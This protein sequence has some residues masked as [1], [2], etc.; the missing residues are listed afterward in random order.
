[1]AQ[2]EKLAARGF[3]LY[4]G[5]HWFGSLN[6]LPNTMKYNSLISERPRFQRIFATT[7][8]FVAVGLAVIF[9]SN[10]CHAERPLGS[11]WNPPNSVDWAHWRGPLQNGHSLEVGLP[12]RFS[13]DGE[14]LLWRKEEFA[15]RATPIVMKDRVY[16]I[17][18]SEPETNKEGE[19]IVCVDAKTGALLWESPHNIFLSD[20]PSERI[21]WSSLIGDS[22]T[23]RVYAL[24]LG[25]LFQCLD[26]STGKV[27]WEHSMLEEYGMLSTYGGRTNFP[28]LF[29]D[30]VIISGVMTG[31][32]QTA[33]PAHR[34]VA[35]DK[36]TGAAIWLMSTRVRPE[37]TTY[38]TPVYTVLNGQAAMVLGAAD[39][40]VY[41]LQPR[42]GK[43]IWKYQASPRGINVTPLVEDGIVY[44]G[45]GEQ[46]ESDRSILGAVF[47]FDGNTSG[48]IPESKLLWSVP[49][50]TVSRSCPV[51]V[52]NRVYYI[53]DGGAMFGVNA[54][55][56][57]VEAEKKLGR[58]M[59]GSLV[60][61]DGKL[62]VGENTGR[63]WTLK[64]TE[65]GL[66][67]LGQT[68]LNDGSEIFGSFAI[69]NGRMFLPT[70]KALYCIGSSNAESKPSP[71]PTLPVEPPLTDMN[72]AHIQ[73]CPVEMLLVPG[74]TAKLQVRGYNAIGQ[75]VKLV[76]DA[77]FTV[78]G[79]GAV[80]DLRYTASADAKG[81]G[82]MITAALGEIKSTARAR[83][84]PPL[85]WSFDFE[86][87]KVPVYWIGSAYRHKPI[88]LPT[89]G[90]GLVKISTIPKGTRSQGFIGRPKTQEYTVQ[91]EFYALDTKNEVRTTKL[92]DMGLVNQR[93]TLALEGSQKLQIRSWVSLL[94]Q[95]FAKTI[96]FQWEPKTWYSL[97]F[98]SENKDGKAVL[99][100][101][102]WKTADPEP[103]V[104]T[105]EAEDETPNTNG[106][107]GIFGNS[108]DA[109]FYID[110]I[111]VSKE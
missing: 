47:A 8:T 87:K 15:T 48:D 95:R 103:D 92:P 64:P 2:P 17:C 111:K 109:E 3:L 30:M 91:G 51:K 78:E 107:P 32:D 85:P 56:G 93:Y 86:D 16:T 63:V 42:T 102:V 104:W 106:S 41:A 26:A 12:D 43:V 49:K 68:R 34:I 28:T 54:K 80:N 39:G 46:N 74:Q 84:I 25:C 36:M 96:E 77:A 45:H 108:T 24:G 73:V 55:T 62:Y 75:F 23:D 29:E 89:G 5:A 66:E 61:S 70:N 1:M 79:G 52:G 27:L 13:P 71:M 6:I 105:I 94:E 11:A 18:R 82:V 65:D 40:A 9:A 57:E 58:I 21:G 33:V 44:C 83:V 101:K 90:N 37:D 10:R 7:V 69:S 110:N 98:K 19:K 50:R 60:A 14:N 97:K 20:A 35:F 99:K 4:L 31:W 100:G 67:V 81:A 88:E 22:E 53:D 72:V 59:F 38:S 76:E